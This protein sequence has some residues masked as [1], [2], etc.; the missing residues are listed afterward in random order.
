[1]HN[2]GFCKSFVKPNIPLKTDNN[3]NTIHLNFLNIS[4]YA[5]IYSD[6]SQMTTI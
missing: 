3:S 4:H 6:F 2:D 1:M 5:L